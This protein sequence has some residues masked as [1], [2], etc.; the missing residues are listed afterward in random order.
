MP[1][2]R[3]VAYKQRTPR[4]DRRREIAGR[5][6]FPDGMSDITDNDD[7]IRDLLGRPLRIAMIGASADPSRDSNRVFRYLLDAGYTV[8]PVTPKPDAIHGVEPVPDLAT[9]KQVLGDIDVVDVFRAAPHTP[10]IAEAAAAAGAGAL[11]LQFNT[12]HEDAV[13]IAI[14]AGMD[15]VADR[16]IK[17]EHRRLKGI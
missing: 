13:R 17:I 1:S 2:T 7:A 11:W 16:C 8:V 4:T 9:A 10:A 6:S 14:D 3:A 12:V 5:P 15:M